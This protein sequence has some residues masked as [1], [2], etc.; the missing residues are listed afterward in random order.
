MTKVS[1]KPKPKPK[2][3]PHRVRVTVLGIS[4]MVKIDADADGGSWENGS[5]RGGPCAPLTPR[6]AVMTIL[7]GGKVLGR[8]GPSLPLSEVVRDNVAAVV[9]E[10]TE[11]CGDNYRD[12][13]MGVEISFWDRQVQRAAYEISPAD[14]TAIA[15]QR[16]YMAIWDSPAITYETSL[17]PAELAGREATGMTSSYAPKSFDV[18]VSLLGEGE[19]VGD[20]VANPALLGIATLA[21]SG[22]EHGFNGQ[23]M[24]INLPMMS[25]EQA[26]PLAEVDGELEKLSGANK[27]ASTTGEEIP[28]EG[29]RDKGDRGSLLGRT[30][31]K[32]NNKWCE[33]GTR[34]RGLGGK[35]RKCVSIKNDGLAEEN[36]SAENGRP[37]DIQKNLPIATA[38]PC[39]VVD[40]TDGAVLRIAL[41]VWE[42]GSEGRIR[43]QKEK[44]M[45]Q[46]RSSSLSP[47]A[48]NSVATDENKHEEASTVD[49]SR[50]EESTAKVRNTSLT[51]F[52]AVTERSVSTVSVGKI[53][54][55]ATAV[56][57]CGSAAAADAAIALRVRSTAASNVVKDMSS[58]R[59]PLLIP[60]PPGSPLSSPPDSPV[61]FGKEDSIRGRR[62]KSTDNVLER[63]LLGNGRREVMEKTIE[64]VMTS[65][66]RVPGGK[67]V[68][69]R[70]SNSQ[71]DNSDH[72]SS[73]RNALSW[74]IFSDDSNA[75]DRFTEDCTTDTTQFSSIV[76]TLGD[77]TMDNTLDTAKLYDKARPSKSS[78]SPRGVKELLNR[79]D[80]SASSN[81]ESE[82]RS[83][84][85]RGRT[86]E[87]GNTRGFG[88]D[89]CRTPSS[90][91][92]ESSSF[93]IENLP[94]D[95]TIG[96]MQTI[97]SALSCQGVA[98]GRV[99]SPILSFDY[100]NSDLS[101]ESISPPSVVRNQ[102]AMMSVGEITN[103]AYAVEVTTRMKEARI[104]SN[105]ELNFAVPL[106]VAFGGSGLCSLS[107]ALTTVDAAQGGGEREGDYFGDYD[108]FSS[109]EFLGIEGRQ[110]YDNKLT[111]IVPRFSMGTTMP[112]E[113]IASQHQSTLDNG[114]M[115]SNHG[116]N[117]DD[118]GEKD[119]Y[120][121]H[122]LL[123]T[124]TTSMS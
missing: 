123:T 19:E 105:A 54:L 68:F 30:K 114:I 116:D 59:G 119:R 112:S 11:D 110:S 88:V 33:I 4:G 40:S 27:N 94:S 73:E 10:D 43:H 52:K 77:D 75:A 2:G 104:G 107:G 9:K 76:D 31:K 53:Q 100:H 71:D 1:P 20:E 102:S 63:I 46:T 51:R 90:N 65:G 50:H 99:A 45:A 86:Y 95:G 96:M 97:T 81:S 118:S 18:H 122:P 108:I 92:T 3:T 39:Y 121:I 120:S 85:L 6:T 15:L 109:A 8:S 66:C 26:C 89:R 69:V 87:W 48:Q 70:S 36:V 111:P 117:D 60:S 57:Q 91:G 21:L 5:K 67:M 79:D 32:K 24:Y 13:S 64:G 22:T 7:R 42:K 72:D 41:E 49:R 17:F 23:P 12:G 74:E 93:E 35:S 62:K 115:I 101:L 106:P 55:A 103:D 78:T 83:F 58:C 124:N 38:A 28:A 56:L 80:S 84:P 16:R 29:R 14:D 34:I 98:N 25:P 82:V 37:I 113:V 61:S 47:S 44:E